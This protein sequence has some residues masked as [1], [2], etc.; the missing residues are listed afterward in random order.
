MSSMRIL[1]IEDDRDAAAYLT[2]AFREVGHVADHAADGLNGYDLAREGAYDVAIVD[3]MLPKMDG[4]SLIGALR[5]QNVETPVLILSALGQVDD[6]VKGLRAGGDDYLAKPYAFSE[7]LARVEVLARRHP[8]GVSEETVY[9]LGDLELDRLSHKVTRAGEE[10][11]LQPREFRLLEYL[12]QHAGKVVTRTMLLEHVWDYHFDPQT[13]VIDVHVSRL[14]AK[15]DRD[16]DTPL[17]HTI[18]GAGYMIR[19]SAR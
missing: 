13:N 5:A 4:L 19:D 10:I 11:I 9:R 12:M 3:R 17:L 14:R 8:K 7:L 15:I 2:K 16:F 1:I 18:R 6:R